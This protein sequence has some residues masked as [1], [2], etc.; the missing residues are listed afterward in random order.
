MRSPWKLRYDATRM[1]TEPAAPALEAPSLAACIN[2]G[3][4]CDV[5]TQ[6]RG[7]RRYALHLVVDER[8]RLGACRSEDGHPVPLTLRWPQARQGVHDLPEAHDRRA[9]DP[10]D[11]FFVGEAHHP[12]RIDPGLRHRHRDVSS[13]RARGA[14]ER[15]LRGIG[16][17]GRRWSCNSGRSCRPR[18]NDPAYLD[19]GGLTVTF[20]CSF[21]SV[22]AG[23]ASLSL[24]SS[25]LV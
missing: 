5:A 15:G 6:A 24:A 4:A 8:A 1:P 22:S 17:A 19:G 3:P 2:P 20:P 13:W 12:V 23:M 18:R 11:R 10:L 7:G 9:Q 25:R 14:G 21:V 16:T